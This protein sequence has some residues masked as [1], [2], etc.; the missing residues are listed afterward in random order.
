MGTMNRK[1]RSPAAT[2]QRTPTAENSGHQNQWD[3]LECFRSQQRQHP[4]CGLDP[5]YAL[6]ESLIR[7]LIS[8]I[9]E[10]F[11]DNDIA[12]EVALT[13]LCRRHNCN[14][15][16]HGRPIQQASLSRPPMPVLS[17]ELFR[18]L[19]W[20]S[21]W[22]LATARHLLAMGCRRVDPIRDRLDAY[23]GWLLTNRDFLSERDRLKD[24]WAAAIRFLGRIPSYPV[25]FPGG[26]RPKKPRAA[27]DVTEE[28]TDDF[29]RF[30]DRWELQRLA[31]WELPEPRGPFLC[32][33]LPPA[34]ATAPASTI[35][36]RFS[37]IIS[38]PKDYPLRAII[39]EAQAQS[40]AITDQGDA[41]SHLRGWLDVFQQNHQGNL[42]FDRFQKI[43][44]LAHY[45]D[46]V[47][48]GRYADRFAGNIAAL[49]SAFASY[50]DDLNADSIRKLRGEM[51]KL[52][53]SH[54]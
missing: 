53:E 4:A 45:R 51:V 43:F 23:T 41:R 22:S 38:L 1:P 35:H 33:V 30:Y 20:D 46:T 10:L 28:F 3:A 5:L 21:S 24:R 54:N 39:E 27:R 29:N 52:R 49:D 9:P 25:E 11:Q 16:F 19:G 7:Q 37:P 36:L 13:D 42:G 26:P 31:T 50:F 34:S 32:G 15:V 2:N 17:A 48:K 47:L 8:T 6:P 12:F 40:L 14:G 44:C 18:S